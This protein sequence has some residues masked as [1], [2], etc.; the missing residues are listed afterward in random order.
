MNFFRYNLSEKKLCQ[1]KVLGMPRI[2][3]QAAGWEARMLPQCYA[4]PWSI[5]FASDLRLLCYCPQTAQPRLIFY[6]SKQ[7]KIS[8]FSVFP[9]N[10]LATEREKHKERVRFKQ[11]P[12]CFIGSRSI[13]LMVYSLLGSRCCNVSWTSPGQTILGRTCSGFITCVEH[14]RIET[15]LG[16][17]CVHLQKLFYIMLGK[18]PFL[19]KKVL[20]R[21]LFLVLTEFQCR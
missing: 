20:H 13:C 5:V 19:C 14:L 11:E 2:K 8:E 9:N 15:A 21:N 17:L 1:K 10:L 6:V 3:P 7:F 16:Q 12:Y 18:N 4:A